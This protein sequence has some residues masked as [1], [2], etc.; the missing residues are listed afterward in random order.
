M[1]DGLYHKELGLPLHESAFK[2]GT[3]P[4]KYSRHAEE[5]AKM[6]RYGCIKLPKTP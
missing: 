4:L 5:A 2:R 3:V 6:D 1:K